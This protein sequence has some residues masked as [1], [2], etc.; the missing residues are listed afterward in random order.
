MHWL[1]G[2][3]GAHK[4]VRRGGD[5][6]MRHVV[7]GHCVCARLCLCRLTQTFVWAQRA[8]AGATCQRLFRSCI[9]LGRCAPPK[10]RAASQFVG[11]L[12]P[13]S[14]RGLCACCQAQ[15]R[16]KTRCKTPGTP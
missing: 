12:P 2:R 7:H 3:N 14:R 15:R 16:L 5:Y 4:E 6:W 10:A 9:F 8:A 13:M 11:T 1:R